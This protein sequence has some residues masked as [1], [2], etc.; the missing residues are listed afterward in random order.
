M[1]SVKNV[2][3][4]PFSRCIW[5]KPPSLFSIWFILSSEAIVSRLE[6]YFM[7]KSLDFNWFDAL[8]C[9][10]AD[11]LCYVTFKNWQLH[12][13]QSG[14]YFAKDLAKA[15]LYI[16]QECQ[17][18]TFWHYE[19]QSVRTTIQKPFR[20]AMETFRSHSLERLSIRKDPTIMCRLDIIE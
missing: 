2:T 13:R 16:I 3:N 7:Y 15:K 17:V 4:E 6:L 20:K 10:I 18:V 9:D 1:I 8:K 14:N 11:C 19:T 5:H 12:M